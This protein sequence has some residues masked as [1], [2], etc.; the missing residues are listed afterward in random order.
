ML[1]Q[2]EYLLNCWYGL[3]WADELD[4]GQPLAR[5]ALGMKLVLFRDGEGQANALLD[6]CPHRF[7]PL[8]LGS[9]DAGVLRCTYHGLGFAGNGKC[10]SN[11]MGDVPERASVR[12]FPVV[13]RDKML[14]FWPGNADLADPS[15]VPDFSFQNR[16]SE[17][18]WVIFGY[19]HVKTDYQ[20]ENDNLMD[21]SHVEF[22][23]AKTFGRGSSGIRGEHQLR[24]LGNEI[25]SN[26]WKSGIPALDPAT[27]RPNG[28]KLDLFLDM[29]WNAPCVMRLHLGFLLHDQHGR[30]EGDREDLP[31][32]FTAHIITPE[33]EGTCHYFWSG[34]RPKGPGPFVGGIDS[35]A[36]RAVFKVAFEAEDKPMLEAVEANMVT[37]F[38]DERPVILPNDAGG[39]RARRRLAKLIRDERAA[40]PLTDPASTMATEAALA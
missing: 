10:V 38:W 23:H 2:R 39:I 4:A 20:N 1:G 32:Q 8:S 26:W 3:A 15:T 9:V 31:G 6:R 14:W 36:G 27:R 17:D 16:A 13:E 28:D 24:D 18:N 29:R 11:P 12:S 30:K 21:L 25:H 34:D 22:L 35:V 19:T 33:D 7:A 5:T 40:L 37:G